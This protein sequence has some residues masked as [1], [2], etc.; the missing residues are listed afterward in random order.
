MS[1]TNQPDG[2]GHQLRVPAHVA[3]IMDGNGRWAR[4]RGLPRTQGHRAGAKSVRAVVEQGLR[5]G[6]HMLTLFAFSSENWRRPRAEVN[7]LLELF[8]STLRAEVN[9][10]IEHDVQLRFIGDLSAFSNKLQRQIAEAEEATRDGHS[11]LLQIAANYGGR[12]DIAQSVRALAREVSKGQ[13]QADAIDEAAIA[14]RLCTAGFPEP[15]LFIRTGGEK[16]ISNFL[17]WQSA[18]AELYFSDLMWPEFDADAFVAALR[19]FG[20]RQRRFGLTSEQVTELA[21]AYGG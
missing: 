21:D 7:T 13:L 14:G 8:M 19:D 20:R 3:I 1:S 12:W 10:L 9:R 11:L 16:R 2:E 18:Y 17:L 5:S 4:Q 15:D 6:V